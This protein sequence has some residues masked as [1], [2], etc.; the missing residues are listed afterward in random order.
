M[1]AAA[2]WAQPSWTPIPCSARL[3]E[4]EALQQAGQETQSVAQRWQAFEVAVRRA[5]KGSTVYAPKPYPKNR[6]EI[7]ENLEYAVREVV[8]GETPI[9]RLT[10]GAQK[11]WA[12][13]VNGTF[14]AE[15]VRVVNWVPDRCSMQRPKP[16]YHLVRLFDDQGQEYARVLLHDT[17]L[18]AEAAMQPAGATPSKIEW[19]ELNEVEPHLRARFGFQAAIVDQQYVAIDGLTFCSPISPCVAFRASGTPYV[20]MNEDLLFELDVRNPMEMTEFVARQRREGLGTV[21]VHDHLETPLLS[22]GYGWA[23]ARRIRPDPR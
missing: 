12:D 16:Y 15:I 7:M 13:T 6:E 20:L 17:G 18:L 14:R 19:P 23:Q 21:G 1:L 10:A 5:Q 22:I 3:D 9:D 11:L 2:S 8:V 4:I